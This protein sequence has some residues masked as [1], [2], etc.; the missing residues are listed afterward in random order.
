M[1]GNFDGS[2]DF[3]EFRHKLHSRDIGRNDYIK[4]VLDIPQMKHFIH[5]EEC[6][7]NNYVMI[8][9]LMTLHCF[10]KYNYDNFHQWTDRELESHSYNQNENEYNEEM[11]CNVPQLNEVMHV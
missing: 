10:K 4:F 3:E 8:S 9:F 11:H 5:L 7:E 2:E 1:D 6:Q